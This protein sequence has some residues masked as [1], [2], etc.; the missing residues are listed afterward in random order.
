MH[1]DKEISRPESRLGILMGILAILFW[2]F[3]GSFVY[4]GAREAGTWPFVTVSMLVG[5][6]I[7]MIF[8]RAVHGELRTAIFLPGRLWLITV[9]CFVVY[10]LV[11][12]WAMVTSTP[13]QVYGV[14]LI[15]YLWPILTVF[16]SVWWVP[17]VRLTRKMVIALV[18]AVGGLCFA[19]KEQIH[20]LFFS[21]SERGISLF[22]HFLPYLLALM[23]AVSWG[24]YS[25]LLA[26]WRE[27]ARNY[28]TSPI[29]FIL[30][31]L[32]A[33]I[34]MIWTNSV[35]A[36]ISSFGMVMTILY[37]IGPL[38]AGYMLWEAALGKAK[39]QTLSLLGA[40]T[41]V[42]SVFLLCIFLRTVPGPELIVAAFLVSGGVVL[43][44]RS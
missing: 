34:V 9:F 17:G 30:I 42:L 33:G 28:A 21:E 35:P 37:G 41:P 26:R 16:F 29:G 13:R 39:V 25:S 2:S 14:N 44:M 5:G 20:D 43:S 11:F 12:P 18:L 4:L 3:G 22:R 1:T 27:W 38:A 10:G 36:R 40:A 24:V 8:R 23:A 15:N 32:I 7:Q 31:G 6:T 19:N